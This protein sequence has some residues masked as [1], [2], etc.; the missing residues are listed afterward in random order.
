MVAL[1]LIVINLYVMDLN[2]SNYVRKLKLNSDEFQT[3]QYQHHV[4]GSDEL[5]RQSSC[6]GLT[7]CKLVRILQ[8]QSHL[9]KLDNGYYQYQHL[10]NQEALFELLINDFLQY[11]ILLSDLPMKQSHQCFQILNE[12]ELQ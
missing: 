3:K 5:K 1:N 12:L 2:L 9:R 4:Q 11:G 8:S 6:V 7:T 10:L